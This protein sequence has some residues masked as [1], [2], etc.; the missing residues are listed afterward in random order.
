[1]KAAE[2]IT[3]HVD[4]QQ[5]NLA[6]KILSQLGILGVIAVVVLALVCLIA[7]FAPWLAPHDPL[8]ID[9]I[10]TYGVPS[11]VNLLGTDALGRDILSRLIWGSR[12]ALLGPLAI[13]FLS[14][15]VAMIM[16]MI[17]AW[18]RGFVDI[19][20]SRVID[21]QFAFP[22]ILLTLLITAT[23]SSGFWPAVVALSLASVPHKAR[24]LRSTL[25]RERSQPYIE[26]LESQGMSGLRIC[27]MHLLPAIWPFFATQLILSFGY[28][29]VELAAIS[30]I[31]LGIQAPA[32]DWGL[33]V[34]QGQAGIIQGEIREA[35]TAGLAIVVVVTAVTI[36]GDRLSQIQREAR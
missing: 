21:I 20:I 36:I 28:A 12:T 25:L 4:K 11:E 24:L 17:A 18:N 3:N 13:V 9:I 35:A 34:A 5:P 1:M 23:F 19:L 26:A 33:M 32:A 29:T 10:N 14:G 16:S 6:F 2:A 22:A 15:T 7:I 8:E 30:F 27:I 31:G